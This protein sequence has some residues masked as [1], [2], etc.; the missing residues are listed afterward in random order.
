MVETSPR[1]VNIGPRERELR[2][3]LGILVLFLALF[4]AVALWW[5]EVAPVW[6]LILVPFYYQGVRFLLDHRTGT[7]PLKAELG[8]EKLD[9]RFSILGTRIQDRSRIAA[10]RRKSRKALAQSIATALVLTGLSYALASLA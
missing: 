8:Q 2:R 3:L 6:Y 7:C 9:A 10:I 5:V 1:H 4:A